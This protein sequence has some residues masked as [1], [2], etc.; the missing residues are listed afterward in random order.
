MGVLPPLVASS[1]DPFGGML[2]MVLIEG[3]CEWIA[4]LGYL[5]NSFQEQDRLI[6]RSRDLDF[7]PDFA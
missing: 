4:G 2:L 7:N 5:A 1:R 3:L 6:Q